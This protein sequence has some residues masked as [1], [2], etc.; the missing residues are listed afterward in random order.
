MPDD[1]YTEA[2]RVE[3]ACDWSDFRSDYG[4]SADPLALEREYR[5]FTAGW[6]AGRHGDQSGPLR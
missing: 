2:E 3:Q 6:R 1:A 4:V 5:A